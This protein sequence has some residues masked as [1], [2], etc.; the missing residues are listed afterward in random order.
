MRLSPFLIPI[1]LPALLCA[2]AGTLHA[3]Q[4]AGSDPLAAMERVLVDVIAQNEKSVVAI[5][6]VRI[7]RSDE[8]LR[9]AFRPDPF[10]RRAIV[11]S[12]PQ[13]TDPDFV[14]NEY[15]TGVVIDRR[16]LIL[17]AY[18][19]LGEDSEYYVTTA[20]RKVYRARIKGADPR[21]DLA[22][23]QIDAGSLE[24]IT[25]GNAQR[26]RKGH[27]A[28]ALGN[29]YAIARD[30]QVSAS[31]GMISNLARKA[32]PTPNEFDSTGKR[33]LH[34]FGTLIQTDAKL[35]LGTSGGPLLNRRGEMIGLTVALAATAGYEQAAGYAI[36]V[37]A[38]FRRVVDVLKEGR[39]V[40]YGFLG[41]QP[42]N[43]RP[44]EVL[45]GVQGI[46]VFRVEPGTPAD[47]HGLKPD[48]L[49][50]AVAGR[51]IYE[52]D[53]LMLEVGRLP[54]ESVARLSVVRDGS[55]R[56]VNVTLAKYRVREQPI[57]TNRPRP[58]RGMRVDYPSVVVSTDPRAR[59]RQPYYDEGVIVTYVAE[60]S[61][62]AEAELQ[63]GMRI[64][65]VG[66]TLVRTP[67]EF[68]AAVGNKSGSVQV[69]LADV[70]KPV[71]TIASGM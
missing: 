31:W 52:S 71:R 27:I 7:P 20:D 64:T 69:R 34:H 47:R 39:E 56:T 1:A 33:T 57:V 37:D 53:G 55:R 22:V 66:R 45:A 36:P 21:S 42:A 17:T 70:D 61:P 68:H 35:N 48:D 44:E 15:G 30:G 62:A 23:L 5:A 16:G 41:I 54:V 59:S 38:T 60:G 9:P 63:P 4:I 11:P 49:I 32:P 29:P 65:H 43:L 3:Q 25:F 8:T 67:K 50:T 19:V 13:P 46:R 51:P 10:G 18:H 2:A 58:W 12:D 40:E 14:P 24:P 6:R 26:V 28:I